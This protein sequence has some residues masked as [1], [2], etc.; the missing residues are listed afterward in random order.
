MYVQKIAVPSGR[1]FMK[2]VLD[3]GTLLGTPNRELQEYSRNIM[4]YKDPGRYIPIIYLLYSW[5]SRF[6][7]PSR[8]PLLER[9]CRQ[10]AHKFGMVSC[11]DFSI[12]PIIVLVSIVSIF[13]G[14]RHSS[15]A[16]ACPYPPNPIQAYLLHQV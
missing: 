13:R 9:A 14:S 6:G 4:E 15:L 5:G 3:K 7:V 11:E 16:S 1:L 2:R 10:R 12:P 8:V